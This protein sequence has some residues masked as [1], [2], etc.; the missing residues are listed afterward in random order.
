MERTTKFGICA[1]ALAAVVGCSDNVEFEDNKSNLTD[2]AGNTLNFPP[3]ERDE[4]AVFGRTTDSTY[5]WAKCENSN[6]KV[7]NYGKLFGPNMDNNMNLYDCVKV[8]SAGKRVIKPGMY[9]Q[10][11][12]KCP[13]NVAADDDKCAHRFYF[14]E[15]LNK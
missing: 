15:R 2:K 3:C 10:D 14:L 13:E 7:K 12:I 9:F 5:R 1:V 4:F 11:C 8:I 6:G